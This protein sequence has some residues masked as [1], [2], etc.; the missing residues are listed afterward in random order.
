MDNEKPKKI[1]ESSREWVEFLSKNIPFDESPNKTTYLPIPEELDELVIYDREIESG[2]TPVKK[3]ERFELMS[4]YG[5]TSAQR[6]TE[7]TDKILSCAEKL[8]IKIPTKENFFM[9]A[10]QIF[11]DKDDN[12]VEARFSGYSKKDPERT[13]SSPILP[14]ITTRKDGKF[15]LDPDDTK[16]KHYSIIVFN[17]PNEDDKIQKLLWHI[18]KCYE[19]E[20]QIP[21]QFISAQND[22][23]YTKFRRITQ[24]SGLMEPEKNK[25]WKADILS[26]ETKAI[27][28]LR[29]GEEKMA[30]IEEALEMALEELDKQRKE[31]QDDELADML[32]FLLYRWAE[33]AKRP[34]DLQRVGVDEYLD[35]RGIKKNK[36]S[37]RSELKK[38]FKQ[39]MSF[40]SRFFIRVYEHVTY[41]KT[42][43]GTEKKKNKEFIEFPPIVIEGRV[44]QDTIWG[45]DYFQWLYKPGNFFARALLS[46]SGRQMA[47]L[48]KKAFKYDPYREKFE[49][50]LTR[51]FASQWRIRA[52]RGDFERVFKVQTLLEEIMLLDTYGKPVQ[53]R[54]R[55]EKALNKLESDKI[56][57]S[58]QYDR[59]DE[60]TTKKRGWLNEWKEA[61]VIVVPPAEITEYYTKGIKEP[62]KK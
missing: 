57:L 7:H 17:N 14:K 58:W 9:E 5:E 16:R 22:I 45:T 6:F 35:L 24:D 4:P 48:D 20:P 3:Y 8:G 11:F 54:D 34:E 61:R 43:K 60:D 31:L 44:G 2:R 39:R 29:P 51:Y 62:S 46:G 40:L 38:I 27:V 25:G 59:F 41:E 15:E 21:I 13:I 37:Y 53:V 52:R 50:R 33:N 55:F 28:E 10:G 56:I 30:L 23:I 12:P 42:K 47:L 18:E 19:E 49:K 36:R 32:D 1:D 26:E